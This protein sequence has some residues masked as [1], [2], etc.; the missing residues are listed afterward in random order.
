M[1]L[2]AGL[3][4]TAGAGSA[5]AQTTLL[6]VYYAPYRSFD[7]Y[8]FGAT[9]SFPDYDGIA[10]EGLFGFG[11][12][13]FDLEIRGGFVDYGE[14][15]DTRGTL[16]ATG[17]YQVVRHNEKFPVDGAVI[18]GLGA[19]LFEGST[20]LIPVG[21]SLGRRLDVEDSEVSIVPYVEPAFVIRTAEGDNF[22]FGVGLGADFKLSRFFD[23]RVS[24]AFG[25][26]PLDGFAISAVWVH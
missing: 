2:V 10:I 14:G 6:P 18:A 5:A 8:E 17:R 21:F 4:V 26:T 25:D 3:A 1:L 15:I 19:H 16:G 22:F 20:L 23:A 9:V 24:V 13:Q 12:K 7:K 11:Y